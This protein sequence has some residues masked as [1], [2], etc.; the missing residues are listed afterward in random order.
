MSDDFNDRSSRK[1]TNIFSR[2]FRHGEFET[3]TDAEDEVINVMNMCCEQGLIDKNCKIMIENIFKFDDTSANEIMTHRNDIVACEDNEPLS[4]V[5]KKIIETGYSRLP[6]YHEDTDN[7]VGVIYAKDLLKFVLEDI[8]KDFSLTDISREIFFVPSSK[9]CSELF[10]EMVAEKKQ[11]AVVVDEY[12]GTDG[13]VSLEDLIEFIM[14]SIQD[15]FDNEE[16]EIHRINERIYSVD[17]SANLEEINQLTGANLP[18]DEYDTIA[19]LILD[20]LGKIPDEN[21]HPIVEFCGVRFKVDEVK[22]RRI[23]KVIVELN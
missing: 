5:V 11:I 18:D 1:S 8:P 21:E 6:V 2:L 17:G 16:E 22:R 12:G 4:S 3:K 20:R 23:V 13:I 10:A 14:G 15:E 19:G 7:M 9:K